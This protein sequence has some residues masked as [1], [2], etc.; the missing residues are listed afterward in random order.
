MHYS[1]TVHQEK[2]LKM[3]PVILFTHLKMIL[4]Q[5]FQFLVFNFQQNKL[6]PNGSLIFHAIGD[7][8]QLQ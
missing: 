5:Y 1:C 8:K 2:K 3:G 4:L 6:Y 7:G